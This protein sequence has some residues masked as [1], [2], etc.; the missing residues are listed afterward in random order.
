MMCLISPL[1]R[2]YTI[3]IRNG[4][5][6]VTVAFHVVFQYGVDPKCR[7]AQ[8]FNVVQPHLYALQ[9][10]AM[11]GVRLGTVHTTLAHAGNVVVG[12]IAVVESVRS[13]QVYQILIAQSLWLVVVSFEKGK[14]ESVRTNF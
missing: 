1:P 10:S 7:C 5:S 6:M 14:I 11:T 9:V 13:N 8:T 2:I 4:I 12:G 3:M